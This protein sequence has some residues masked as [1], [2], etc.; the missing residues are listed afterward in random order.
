MKESSPE[1]LVQDIEI[2]SGESLKR[3]DDLSH[4]AQIRL[5]QSTGR[6]N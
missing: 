3:K 5:F 6:F 4:I 1:S 2:F